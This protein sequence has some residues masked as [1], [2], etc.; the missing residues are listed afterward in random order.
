[1]SD[2]EATRLSVE[3]VIA[4][5]TSISARIR[6][7]AQAGYERTE[8]ARILKIRYQHVRGVLVDVHARNGQPVQPHEARGS[9]P[10]SAAEMPRLE[11]SPTLL[12][13]S[14]FRLIGEWAPLS[15]VAFHLSESA[16]REPGIYAFV[17]EGVVRYIG[18]TQTDLHTRMGHYR[19]GHKGHRTSSRVKALILTCLADGK[20]VQVLVATPEPLDWNGLPVST[21]AGLEVALIRSMRP[22]WNMLG[23]RREWPIPRLR[24]T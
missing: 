4:G 18:L 13:K 16:P 14:G 11:A 8:I 2:V 7:L 10:G 9:R 20:P 5:L 24:K 21:A 19:R 22:E 3:D 1:M 15:D 12:I 17:V 6:A 23:A